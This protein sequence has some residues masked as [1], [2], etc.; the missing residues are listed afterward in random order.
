M[1]H[2]DEAGSVVMIYITSFIKTRS[3]IQKLIQEAYTHRQQC[4]LISLLSFLHN[5]KSRVNRE[6]GRQMYR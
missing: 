4:D 5:K 6:S 2:A 1:K 3:D